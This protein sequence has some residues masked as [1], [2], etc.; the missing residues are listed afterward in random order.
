ME[1]SAA[2]SETGAG[3]ATYYCPQCGARYSGPGVCVNGHG[4]TEVLPLD[5]E[6][7]AKDGGESAT[8]VLVPP[9]AA[10][11]AAA[12]AAAVHPDVPAVIAGIRDRLTHLEQLIGVGGGNA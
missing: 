1:G 10:A 12:E 2:E 7:A 8:E 11:V 3:A 9:A 6:A 4:A 5:T